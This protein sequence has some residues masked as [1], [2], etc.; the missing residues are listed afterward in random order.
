MISYPHS[1][2]ETKEKERVSFS[3]LS[4]V[5]PNVIDCRMDVCLIKKKGWIRKPIKS[6]KCSL[7]SCIVHSDNINSL[8]LKDL[9]DENPT[10][11]NDIKTRFDESCYYV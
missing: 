9:N 11:D 1:L 7:V 5:F 2:E 8:D 10:E 6:L 3:T 4:S